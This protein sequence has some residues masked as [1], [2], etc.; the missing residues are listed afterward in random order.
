MTDWNEKF[1]ELPYEVRNIAYHVE[2]QHRVSALQEAR[3]LLRRKHAK[4]MQELTAE[5][6][7]LEQEMVTHD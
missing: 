1:N 5:I 3:R 6:A 4:V 7:R 2:L